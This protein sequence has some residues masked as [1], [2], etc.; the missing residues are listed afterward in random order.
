[1]CICYLRIRDNDYGKNADQYLA[2]KC[3]LIVEAPV[4]LPPSKSLLKQ[5]RS[6][7]YHKN[8]KSLDLHA[9]ILSRDQY[10]QRDFLKTQPD[11]SQNQYEDPLMQY[12]T[13]SGESSRLGVVKGKLI[14]SKSL[15]T[16]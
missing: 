2:M 8:P 3:F 5:P 4:V 7:I 13:A 10:K 12:S 9:W 6:N 11:A 16:E 15:F 1:M 14:R